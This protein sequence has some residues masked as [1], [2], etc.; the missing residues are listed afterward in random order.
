VSTRRRFQHTLLTVLAALIMAAAV[1]VLH[2]LL[3]SEAH[4]LRDVS[5]KSQRP[6]ARLFI[7]LELHDERNFT[8]ACFA[9]LD[10]GL[11]DD[12]SAVRAV[13]IHEFVWL[14]VVG[15]VLDQDS[16]DL[17]QRTVHALDVMNQLRS[18]VSVRL[19]D[20]VAKVR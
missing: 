16:A 5:R 1:K 19:L 10:I 11:T 14:I 20:C 2:S 9:S 17:N 7:V 4:P 15:V 18:E 13:H 3:R 8:L 12:R 6:A